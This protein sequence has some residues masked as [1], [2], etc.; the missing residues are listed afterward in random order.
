MPRTDGG[1]LWRGG[2]CKKRDEEQASRIRTRTRLM[3]AKSSVPRKLSD[4]SFGHWPHVSTT[5][6]CGAARGPPAGGVL[7][8]PASS[9]ARA[10]RALERGTRE[11]KGTSKD[12]D[13]SRA[14]SHL[15]QSP[16]FSCAVAWP[17]TPCSAP[18]NSPGRASTS[19]HSLYPASQHV[20]HALAPTVRI[21]DSLQ[22]HSTYHA[23]RRTVR[24]FS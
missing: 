6:Q 2:T 20:F 12:V 13:E 4:R 1:K 8:S 21:H 17:P 3:S 11:A 10:Q 9:S 24:P 16:L 19:P 18:G 15:F 5:S 14:G 7:L 23:G 22:P